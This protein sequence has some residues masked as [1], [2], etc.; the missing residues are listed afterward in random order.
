MDIYNLKR[1][2]EMSLNANNSKNMGS[3]KVESAPLLEP[4]TYPGRLQ[5]VIDLG[6]QPQNPWQGQEKDPAYFILTT[7]ELSDEFMQD[8]DGNAIKERPRFVSE[9]FP[10][11]SLGAEK[12][13][14]TN[15]Y[16]ALDPTVAYNGDWAKLIGTPALITLVNNP[17]S[18]KHA[19]KVFTNIAGVSPMRAKEAAILSPLVNTP[20]SFD[21]DNV[22]I[23]SFNV[24]PEWIK[25]KIKEGLEFKGSALDGLI[26]GAVEDTEEV[27]TPFDDE[28][29]F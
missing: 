1:K 15:R 12:A 16:M 18:G 9:S 28:I 3:G 14:S 8:E 7:Y 2:I 24:L 19:G 6:K 25:D 20:V 10:L 13:K 21:M 22:S 4:A 17:G 23:D 27:E 11:F 29:P 26:N 5:S